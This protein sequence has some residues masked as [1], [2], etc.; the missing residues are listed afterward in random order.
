MAG[1]W[2]AESVVCVVA[3]T[4]CLSVLCVVRFGCEL[5]VESSRVESSLQDLCTTRFFTK[6]LQVVGDDGF[7]LGWRAH[8]ASLLTRMRADAAGYLRNT[9]DDMLIDEF[10]A[11]VSCY[12]RCGC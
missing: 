1:V 2:E 10:D 11:A 8:A 4:G 12:L 6:T 9:S 3:V 5:C 7:L